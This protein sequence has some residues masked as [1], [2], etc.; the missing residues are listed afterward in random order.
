MTSVADNRMVGMLT[1][2]VNSARRNWDWFAVLGIV[3]I[4]AGTL[5]AGL[6]FDRSAPR[7]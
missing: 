3:Q 2:E 6:R 7:W 5:A 4:V 1:E